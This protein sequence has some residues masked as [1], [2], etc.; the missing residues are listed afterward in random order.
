MPEKTL[1]GDQMQ[2]VLGSSHGDIEQAAFFLDLCYHEIPQ[3]S[4]VVIH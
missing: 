2:M 1:W 4:Q 3:L